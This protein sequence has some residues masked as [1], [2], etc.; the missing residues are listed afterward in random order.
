MVEAK[1]KGVLKGVMPK[2]NVLTRN[3]VP[4]ES[5]PKKSVYDYHASLS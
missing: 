1:K 4:Q 5:R 2:V 3:A